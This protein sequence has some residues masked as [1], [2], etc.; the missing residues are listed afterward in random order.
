MQL[1]DTYIGFAGEFNKWVPV[2]PQ[3]FTDFDR[4]NERVTIGMVGVPD[5]SVD[6]RFLVQTKV[7]MLNHLSYWRP[8]S[9]GSL[10]KHR[11]S[12]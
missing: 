12:T 1:G 2:S 3:R 6:M 5:E 10:K 11:G 4:N 7:R 8:C 9:S